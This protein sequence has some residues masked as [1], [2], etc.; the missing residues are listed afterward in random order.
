MTD[1][2]YKLYKKR[3]LNAIAGLHGLNMVYDD[4]TKLRYLQWYKSFDASSIWSKISLLP[5]KKFG[6]TVLPA[7]ELEAVKLLKECSANYGVIKQAVSSS[8]LSGRFAF[9]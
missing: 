6:E 8:T 1:D 4:V 7:E 3:R 9:A 2:E 5:I